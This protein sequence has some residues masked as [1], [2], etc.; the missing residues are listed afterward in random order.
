MFRSM[1]Y[2]SLFLWL[3]GAGALYGI[4]VTKGLPH[5]IWSYT[6]LDNGDQHNPFAKRHY[7]S[8]TFVG[9]YGVFTVNAKNGRCG[10]VRLLKEQS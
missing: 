7:T 10:W 4:Y 6:F 9:P 3:I 2:L 1:K 8:C 5:V